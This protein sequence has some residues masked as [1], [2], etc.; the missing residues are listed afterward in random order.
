VLCGDP[1][2]RAGVLLKSIYERICDNRPYIQRMNFVNAEIT[3]MSVN[4][5]VTGKISFANMVSDIC[6]RLPDADASTVLKAV[7]CDA[8]IGDKYLSP[9]LGYGGPRFPRDNAAFVSMARR[10][11]AQADFF[12]ATDAIN[13]RQ[14]APVISLVRELFPPGTVEVLG[15]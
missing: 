12:Q 3:K 14:P 1:D 9:A 15:F 11:G 5:F 6:D 10:V 13:N 8:R 7:G 2:S 4:T